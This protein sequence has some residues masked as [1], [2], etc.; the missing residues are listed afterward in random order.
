LIELLAVTRW[1]TLDFLIIDM[2]PGISD[3]TLDLIRL[4]KRINFLIVTTPSQLAFETIRKLA[5]LLSELEVPIMGVI[6][7]MKIKESKFVQRR[8]EERNI[9]F[10]GEIP[11]D[12][13]LEEAIGSVDKLLTTEFGKKLEDLVAKNL[14]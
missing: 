6:E 1:D 8:T 2:P 13:E 10:W 5:A 12:T 11:Y 9:A 7:N 4:V 14:K 3:A